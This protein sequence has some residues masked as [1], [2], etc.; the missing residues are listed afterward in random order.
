[1]WSDNE[2]T[3][4]RVR[5]TK[6]TSAVPRHY[7]HKNG[8]L[9]KTVHQHTIQTSCKIFYKKRSIQVLSK[10]M[11]DPPYHLI[12]NPSIIIFGIKWKKKYMKIDLTSRL[13][14]KKNYRSRSVWKDI[15]FN[16]PEIWRSINQFS[17]NLKVVKEREGQYIKMICG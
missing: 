9:Y 13:R 4:I 1:M 11:N 2:C 17:G 5:F 8:F 3:A 16:L 10:H 6:R 12:A 7:K 14:A 15:V